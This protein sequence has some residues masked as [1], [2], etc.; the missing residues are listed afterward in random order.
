MLA[1]QPQEPGAADGSVFDP[2]S[3]AIVVTKRHLT[4]L[5]GDNIFLLDHA[6]VEIAAQID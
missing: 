2:F 6:F 3:F 1:D 4:V 5:A